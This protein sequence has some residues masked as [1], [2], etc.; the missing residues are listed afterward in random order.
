MGIETL[1]KQIVEAILSHEND[2]LRCLLPKPEDCFDGD[3]QPFIHTATMF[4]NPVAVRILSE[5]GC[6]T[7]AVW[8]NDT[9]LAIACGDGNADCARVLIEFGANVNWQQ[10]NGVTP[11][12]SAVIACSE[13]VVEILLSSGADPAIAT[14]DGFRAIDFAGDCENKGIG[15]KIWNAMQPKLTDED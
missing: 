10:E 6:A 15:D 14:R 12:M 5:Q 11:L 4:N 7:D 3:G 2:L 13:E 9:A 1:Q 8:D